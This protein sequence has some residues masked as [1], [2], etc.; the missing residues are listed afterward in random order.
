MAL[1]QR[2]IDFIESSNDIRVVIVRYVQNFGPVQESQIHSW[3]KQEYNPTHIPYILDYWLPELEDHGEIV[4]IDNLWHAGVENGEIGRPRGW[5]PIQEV[6]SLIRMMILE[7]T[8]T[9]GYKMI[10]LA[11]L[12]GGG[13]S[14]LLR[15]VS[16]T[17]L[18]AHET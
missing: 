6:R 8:G 14:T 4:Q 3:L 9:T 13:K 5:Q 2:D 11:G 10:F 15:A 1:T 17:H 12:P 7:S 16:Y 18:R